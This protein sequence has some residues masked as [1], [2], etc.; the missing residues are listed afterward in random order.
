VDTQHGQDYRNSEQHARWCR[1]N[2]VLSSRLWNGAR[3]EDTRTGI[4]RCFGTFGELLQG[5]LPGQEREFLVTLPI[6]R[7]ST[8]RFTASPGSREIYVNPSH[9]EKCRQ[10]AEELMHVF[11]LDSEGFLS[12]QSELPAGKGCAS[13]SA[14]MVATALAIQSAL[15]V[16]ISRA[17]LARVMSSIEPSDGVMYQGIVSFYHREGVLRKFLGYLPSLIIVGLDEGGQ[18]DTVEFNKRSKLFD[19]AHRSEYEKLLLGMERAVAH[20]DLRSLGE[21]STRSAILNQ[22]ILP[23]TYL[24]LLLDM[25]RR[26]EALGV[27]VAH[28][29]TH[30]GLLFDPDSLDRSQR[31][32]AIVAEVMQHCPDVGIYRTHDFRRNK[33]TRKNILS[34]ASR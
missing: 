18:V 30:L 31:L 33:R 22:D 10:L 16:S 29:G 2:D 8:A 4:G 15:G 12:V 5:V 34:T 9:K 24:D 3:E 25:R 11:D 1:Q 32:P 7:Y 6:A 20:G 27:V 19:Q 14:D 17:S 23:K 26:Y 13:S 21:I 28:S